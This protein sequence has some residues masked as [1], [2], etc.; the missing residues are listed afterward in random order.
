MHVLLEYIYFILFDR[1]I[2][3]FFLLCQCHADEVHSM[4]LGILIVFNEL[5]LEC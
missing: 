2:F 5:T 3:F 4:H 1:K